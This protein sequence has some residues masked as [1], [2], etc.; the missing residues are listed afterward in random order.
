MIWGCQI[1]SQRLEQEHLTYCDIDRKTSKQPWPIKETATLEIRMFL[2]RQYLAS[3]ISS[4]TLWK[5]AQMKSLYIIFIF[6]SNVLCH[7]F[8]IFIL[9]VTGWVKIWALY[10][11]F[12]LFLSRYKQLLQDLGDYIGD[13]HMQVCLRTQ[14]CLNA[15]W[16]GFHFMG[17]CFSKD[18][19]LAAITNSG[20]SLSIWFDFESREHCR[21]LWACSKCEKTNGHGLLL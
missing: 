12:C 14:D 9:S 8:K 18:K 1:T 2:K 21:P 19:N 10:W 3:S 7:K 15:S 17:W 6:I 5:K 20:S 4:S 13:A 11:Y 16:R